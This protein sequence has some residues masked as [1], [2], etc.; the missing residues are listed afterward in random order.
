ML[1]PPLPGLPDTRHRF[2]PDLVR[3]LRSTVVARVAAGE[4]HSLV[5]SKAG[6]TYS[7]GASGSGQCGR[8]DA[9]FAPGFAAIPALQHQHVTHI[10][11]GARHSVALC[12]SDARS[13]VFVFGLNAS[14]Q[15]GL[16]DT[17]DRAVPEEVVSLRGRAWRGVVCGGN[18][19]FLLASPCAEPRRPLTLDPEP[20]SQLLHAAAPAAAPAAEAGAG[21][22]APSPTA[23]SGGAGGSGSGG[24]SPG[25]D[26]VPD[27]REAIAAAE[28]AA[29][30]PSTPR[31]PI[32]S[33]PHRQ[34]L[35]LRKVLET[36]FCSVSVL[37]GSFIRP[38]HPGMPTVASAAHCRLDLPAVRRA[39]SEILALRAAP[40]LHTLGRATLRLTDSLE[41][42]PVDEPENMHVFLIL[43]ENP[44]LQQT[45][46]FHLAIRRAVSAMLGLPPSRREMLFGW[47]SQMS[48]E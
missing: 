17:K 35:R 44:L 26:G 7:A 45:S 28:D 27:V 41:R 34:L 10:A 4:L 6:V 11:C 18:S 36:A 24:A 23:S 12:A 1:T 38:W 42:C 9:P 30:L 25:G 29:V 5:L 14:G 32:A 20:L 8:G 46:K 22:A 16:G 21:A 48:S 19:T 37:N 15:L 3:S 40:V 43:L 33:L 47:V 31:L 39:Y 13:R 2:R